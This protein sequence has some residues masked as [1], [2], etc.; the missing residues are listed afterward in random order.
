MK[1]KKKNWYDYLWVLSTLYMVIGFFNILFAWLG[2]ICFLVPLAI[3][4]I[5]GNKIYCNKYCGR[6]QLFDLLG[7]QLKLSRK[8]DIPHFIRSNWFRYGFLIFF[9]MMFANMLFST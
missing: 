7:K 3:S 9:L 5:N 4:I 8:K 2:M 1:T 6:G